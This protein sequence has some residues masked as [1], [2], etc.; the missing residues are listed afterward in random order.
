[1][2]TRRLLAIAAAA[3]VLL[4]SGPT[5]AQPRRGSRDE[6]IQVCS[7]EMSRRFGGAPVRVEQVHRVSRRGNRLSVWARMRAQRVGNDIR[8]DV[9]CAVDFSGRRPR[10]ASFSTNRDSTSGGGWG[11]GGSDERARRI[12]WREAQ[13][14][15]YPVSRVLSVQPP[16]R[17]GGRWVILRSGANNE[18]HC[19][20]RNG[21]RD[22]RYRR[23]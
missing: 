19:L 12:C 23:R 9:D 1:M 10:I 17:R 22:L 2:R 16:D 14:A 21:V 20:Y 13:S 6:A 7:S 18:V 4:S 5:P 15:G 3:L 11:S 8:R